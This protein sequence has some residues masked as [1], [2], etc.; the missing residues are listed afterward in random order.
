[1]SVIELKDLTKHFFLQDAGFF[2]QKTTTVHAVDGINLEIKNKEI[3]G[4]VGESGCGKTTVGKCILRF[5]EPTSGS[6]LFQGTD[7]ST[8]VEKEL[9]K[10]ILMVFQDPYSSLTPT[11]TIKT[12]LMEPLQIHKMYEDDLEGRISDLLTWVGLPA[13][14]M[15]RY[16]HELSGGEKQRVGIARALTV[17]PKLIVA[18]E[19]IASLD[20]SV[21]AKMLNLIK[22]LQ[23]KLGFSCLFISHD[24]GIVKNICDRVAVMYLGQIVELAE[25]EEIFNH[26]RHPYTQ[27]LIS[28]NPVPRPDAKRKRIILKGEVPAPINPP[29]ACRFHPRCLQAQPIC[30]QKS[31]EYRE[32]HKDHFVACHFA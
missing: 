1:M 3:L 31:P 5:Y 10:N 30:S 15:Y 17:D 28:A 9:R 32:L 6:I 22:D 26:P 4:L 8:I 23:E 13:D 14:Y 11:M 16:P 19:P 25:A 20:V 2:S 7:L 24:L 29:E 12:L 18:D 21:K 27:A